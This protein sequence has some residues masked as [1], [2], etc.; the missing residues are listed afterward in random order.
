MPYHI[1]I[2]S[3]GENSNSKIAEVAQALN[4]TQAE[5]QFALPPERLRN[6]GLVFVQQEYQ[7]AKVF[8]FLKD[9]RSNAKGSRPY[10]LAVLNSQLRSEKHANLFGSHEA[11]DGLA[12]VTLNDHQH[13]AD[14]YRSYLAYYFIRYALSFVCP[15]LKSHKDARGCFFDFKGNK[16]DLKKSLESGAFCPQCMEIF[17]KSLNAEVRTAIEKMIATMKA[18]QANSHAD[19]DARALAGLVDIGIITVRED[20]FDHMLEQFPSRRHAEGKNRLYE[21]AE[22]K[23]KGNEQLGIAIA[24]CPEQGQGPASAV[25]NDM[26][27]DFSPPWIFLVGIAGGFPD[28]EYSLGDVLLASRVHDFAVSAA[29]EGGAV[30]HQQQGGSVHLDVEKL[31]THLKAIKKELGQWSSSK[32]IGSEKPVEE[33]PD[34][35]KSP[36]FYGTEEWKTKV[37]S[38]LQIHFPKKSSAREPIFK[39]APMITSNT[40][41]KDTELAS[42]W[43]KTARHAVGVE[44]ELGGVYLAARYGG[45]GNTRVLAI[46][47]VS[48]IVGYKRAPQ[49]TEYACRSAAAFA[50]ALIT[51]GRIR[52]TSNSI[53]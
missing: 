40:L 2:L 11:A 30:E 8:E 41:V 32:N 33:I 23:T 50:Y 7:T 20:E 48:D 44:M 39:V 38:S 22:V 47:G 5:F 4:V 36:A 29:L 49:W 26:I 35:I 21:Y 12:V 24:R 14:S 45:N 9:Y 6:E 13:F 34:D 3:V 25:A 17:G 28:S 42:Q 18:L 51:S 31:L 16:L 19:L 27:S 46:R 53:H 37:S 43:R 15:N 1:E 52:K 10:L